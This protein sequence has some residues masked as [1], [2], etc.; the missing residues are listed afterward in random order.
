MNLLSKFI[1][2]SYCFLCII[3]DLYD[4]LVNNKTLF[5]IITYMNSPHATWF[6]VIELNVKLIRSFILSVCLSV[7]NK[8]KY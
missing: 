5:Y 8:E 6:I 7:F 3:S 4:H 2:Y 1:S